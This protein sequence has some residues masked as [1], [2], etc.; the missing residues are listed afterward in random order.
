[1]EIPDNL[2]QDKKVFKQYFEKYFKDCFDSFPKPIPYKQLIKEQLKA[3]P[4]KEGPN[5][6][7]NKRNKITRGL[8]KFSIKSNYTASMNI[9]DRKIM[10]DDTRYNLM[11]KYLNNTLEYCKK[12]KLPIPNTEFVL[13]VA[14][15]FPYELEMNDIKY[16]MFCY[17]TIKN[18]KYPLLPDNTFLEFSFKK[19]FGTGEDWDTS[20]KTFKENIYKKPKSN[21]LFFRGKDTT[22]LR[23]GLRRIVYEEQ[24]KKTMKIELLEGDVK[25][26]PMYKFSHY[27]YLFDLPGRY[28]WSN[29]FPRLFLCNRLVVKLSNDIKQYPDE[30]EYMAFTDLLMRPNVDYLNYFVTLNELSKRNETRLR[31]NKKILKKEL[32]KINDKIKSLDEKEYKKITKSGNTRINQLTNEHLY[33]YLYYGIMANHN[34]FQKHKNQTGGRIEISRFKQLLNRGREKNISKTKTTKHKVSINMINKMYQY[35]W[36]NRD[37]SER[38]FFTSKKVFKDTKIAIIVPYMDNEAQERAPQLDKFIKHFKKFL[39]GFKYQIFIIEQSEFSKNKYGGKF[40]RGKLLNIGIQR[41]INQKY[42]VIISHDVDLYPRTNM[43]PYY[44][45]I[46]KYPNHIGNVWKTKYTQWEFVGGILAMTP[47]QLKEVNGYP[48]DFWGWGGEDDALYNRITKKI[49]KILKPED[50]DM[51]EWLHNNSPP[52]RLNEKK[53]ENI[54][55]DLINW[56]KDGLNSLKYYINEITDYGEK[57]EDKKINEKTVEKIMKIYK[58]DYNFIKSKKNNKLN[59]TVNDNRYYTLKSDK[60]KKIFF[61]NAKAGCT[62]LKKFIY[63]TEEEKEKDPKKSIHSIIG[64]LNNNKYYVKMT[65]QNLKKYT[66]YEKVLIFRDPVERLYSFYKNKVLDLKKDNY[67]KKNK[68]NV[69]SNDVTFDGFVDKLLKVPQKQYQHHLHLQT[70]GINRE[71]IDK[72]INLKDLSDY[73]KKTADYTMKQENLT[74][75]KTNITKINVD[76]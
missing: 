21:K 37:T 60:F 8:V 19:R 43:L 71:W 14:D 57:R 63:E 13:F 66:D 12:N 74:R 68:S 69:V 1:M 7:Y 20:K 58:D 11:M 15:R 41:A 10:K 73:L 59:K 3:K 22:N 29:R 27:K 25:Y 62:S 18:K 33:L 32:E 72:I 4:I 2:L 76:I 6:W 49:G 56:K 9:K 67:I 70:T 35:Y 5:P 51:N 48:N 53:K 75:G 28:E 34:Y 17:A 40:N 39:K 54:L 23:T 31:N 65:P 52:S 26:V 50:G 30:E 55:V 45:C 61:W 16:P 46:P 64:Q 38:I 42:D 44:S 36:K 24:D 47:K